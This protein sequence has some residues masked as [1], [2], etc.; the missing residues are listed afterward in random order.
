M[1]LREIKAKEVKSKDKRLL[2]SLPLLALLLYGLAMQYQAYQAGLLS[3]F[4]EPDNIRAA[5]G[6]E[7]ERPEGW[8]TVALDGEVRRRGYF[9]LGPGAGLRELVEYAGPK[10]AADISPLDFAYQP[11][12][13]DSFYIGRAGEDWDWLAAGTAAASAE[14]VINLNTATLEEL[15]QL[16]GIGPGRAQAII[17]YRAEHQGFG[18]VEELLGVKGIGEKIYEQLKDRVTVF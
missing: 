6:F 17:D 11:R 2:L 10:G 16:P 14:Q 5:A 7:A 9:C 12:Q 18:Y 8:V 3:P 4:P 1:E 13:G 15:Q